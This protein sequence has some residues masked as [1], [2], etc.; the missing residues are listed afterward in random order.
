MY[1]HAYL[2]YEVATSVGDVQQQQRRGPACSPPERPSPTANAQKSSENVQ[3][4]SQQ[5]RKKP[6]P[7]ARPS[8]VDSDTARENKK[9]EVHQ[10]YAKIR[11]QIL[12]KQGVD[13]SSPPGQSRGGLGAKADMMS[14]Q[15]GLKKQPQ[16]MECQQPPDLPTQGGDG[17]VS[18]PSTAPCSKPPK[19]FESHSRPSCYVEVEPDFEIIVE[20]VPNQISQG[21]AD[22]NMWMKVKYPTRI[23]S[24]EQS[25]SSS[26]L[27][28]SD[29]YSNLSEL[30]L[31]V[32]SE[33]SGSDS[34]CRRQ[35]RSFSEQE[36]RKIIRA[37][38]VSRCMFVF[39]I[40]VCIPNEEC[41]LCTI[42]TIQNLQL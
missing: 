23:D 15:G 41:T 26:N 11:E 17:K 40:Y 28:G 9:K 4:S 3:T 25:S 27:A 6:I 24:T 34:M 12:R 2:V 21:D 13:T 29:Y 31:D 1:I 33:G 8:M 7:P 38:T 14:P 18:S 16:L 22:D 42:S 30:Q 10:K 19:G 39:E 36:D 5:V 32:V 35:R 37:S 20:P